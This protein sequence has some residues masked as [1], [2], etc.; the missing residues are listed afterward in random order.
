VI[1]TRS[2]PLA[3]V[4]SAHGPLSEAGS[5]LAMRLTG[6]RWVVGFALALTLVIEVPFRLASTH[7]ADGAYFV[8]MFWAPHDAAQYLSAMRQGAASSSWLI[9]DRFTQE[10]HAPALMY[11][12]YVGLGKLASLFGIGLENAFLLASAAG[13]F[14]LCLALYSFTGLAFR[15]QGPRRLAL[16]LLALSSGLASVLALAQ[17]VTG[18]P[19]PLNSRELNDPELNTFLTFYTA[20][21]LMFGLGLLLLAARMYAA[22]WETGSWSLRAPLVLTVVLLG[23]TNPFPLVPLCVVIGAHAVL[24][25]VLRRRIDLDGW[26]GAV[27]AGLAALPFVVYSYLTFT[28]DPFWGA[29]YGAQNHT[30]S[31]TVLDLLLGIGSLIPFALLG[32]RGFVTPLTPGKGLVLLWLILSVTLMYFP[33]GIQRRFGLGLHPTLTLVASYGVLAV[34]QALRRMP[35]RL[36]LLRPFATVGMGQLLF[37]SSAHMF[38][39]GMTIALAPTMAWNTYAVGAG[40]DRSS[41]QQASVHAAGLWM[42]ERV[43]QDDLVLAATLTGNYLAGATPGR[44]YVGHWVA[45]LDYTEKKRRA[46]WFFGGQLDAERRQFLIETGADYVVIGPAERLLGASGYDDPVLV[47]VLSERDV[48]VYR[49]ESALAQAAGQP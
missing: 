21:H 44:V 26:S 16:V 25:T 47:P 22:C 43:S 5:A 36:R 14:F 6:M 48:T 20:P 19:M 32:L 12:F 40:A 2:Q 46:E 18:I 28:L 24:M 11:T 31:P 35:V 13:R 27:G 15:E 30:L 34:A 10:S 17:L 8:G 9:V 38:I 37:G 4:A 41:Y 3:G 49:V 33:M 45:T 7:L 23:L 42:A 39:V 1:G 29:T